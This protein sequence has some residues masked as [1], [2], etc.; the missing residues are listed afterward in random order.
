MRN[1]KI[2]S[3]DLSREICTNSVLR[4]ITQKGVHQMFGFRKVLNKFRHWM[5]KF[6]DSNWKISH[7]IIAKPFLSLISNN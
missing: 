4:L 6:S 1:T 5:N 7:I 2:I 3:H